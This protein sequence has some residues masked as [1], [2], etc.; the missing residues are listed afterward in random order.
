MSCE[1]Y[2]CECSE[3][4]SAI[5]DYN[6][7]VDSL[8]SA[9]DQAD[10]SSK[11][12]SAVEK[13]NEGLK[14]VN[15][16]SNPDKAPTDDNCGCPKGMSGMVGKAGGKGASSVYSACCLDG[17]KDDP[18]KP[19]AETPCGKD[20]DNALITAPLFTCDPIEVP[21]SNDD[22][23]PGLTKIKCVKDSSK[24][25]KEQKGSVTVE[26]D[27]P[28][29]KGRIGVETMNNLDKVAEKIEK[30]LDY[31]KRVD[32]IA[33]SAVN[34]GGTNG[35]LKTEACLTRLLH[36]HC[37]QELNRPTR[38][39][40]NPGGTAANSMSRS[41]GSAANGRLGAG[42]DCLSNYDCCARLMN[43][44]ALNTL[45]FGH[46]KG[47]KP[48]SDGHTH[49]G[50][51]DCGQNKV[52]STQRI[53][54]PLGTNP[55]AA[56]QGWLNSMNK[57]F[58]GGCRGLGTSGANNPITDF[59]I[60]EIKNC[61][62]ADDCTEW[63][64][65]P[66][67]IPNLPPEDQ[68][69]L[70]KKQGEV[71]LLKREIDD[72]NAGIKNLKRQNDILQTQ[73]NKRKETVVP[74]GGAEDPE[75]TR[76]EGLK[77]ANEAA[78]ADLEDQIKTHNDQ[79]IL[80][81]DEMLEI[82]NNPTFP[83]GNM[84]KFEYRYCPAN[85]TPPTNP[86]GP[87]GGETGGPGAGGAGGGSGQSHRNF[88]DLLNNINTQL[89]DAATAI[90]CS[91]PFLPIYNNCLEG[92][93]GRE[94]YDK[95][96]QSGPNTGPTVDNGANNG[97]GSPCNHNDSVKTVT[98]I[99]NPGTANPGGGP[100]LPCPQDQMKRPECIQRMLRVLKGWQTAAQPWQEKL[101]KANNVLGKIRGA[102]KDI[103]NLMNDINPPDP[104]PCGKVD[105]TDVN[106]KIDK[107][108]E[109]L[110]KAQDALDELKN[111]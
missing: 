107:V 95:G 110:E 108:I 48:G 72:F 34:V 75:V 25:C 23:F 71:T 63:N 52:K 18:W 91:N 98:G 82:M 10:L 78:I 3:I 44:L 50:I 61:V 45:T 5:D 11:L 103:N 94:P 90:G 55:A 65:N 41:C 30:T 27:S 102:I 13:I 100:P 62:S 33:N 12:K 66:G 99:W 56:V 19:G 88:F 2:I 17:G 21:T 109:A 8:K 59:E 22:Q 38:P 9:M 51:P 96:G 70:A 68:A 37:R 77:A 85:S 89:G 15:S 86:N 20:A 49:N 97:N 67:E 35:N 106:K 92:Q 4:Q 39:G 16:G 31:L 26:P 46:G 74:P 87:R 80:L 93:Q 42:L 83:G 69:E 54:V 60:K 36:A 101:Q 76:L 57:A 1:K 73:I 79:I 64:K 24:K 53:F 58:P 28:K 6:G 84:V 104:D 32:T 81:Q 43:R 14:S 7:A 111:I 40:S 47:Y 29:P 105:A